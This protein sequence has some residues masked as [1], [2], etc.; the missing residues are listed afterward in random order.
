[1]SFIAGAVGSKA[2]FPDGAQIDHLSENTVGHGVRVRGISDL[3]TYPVIAGDVGE[4]FEAA[5][6]PGYTGTANTWS[7]AS[8]TLS[9]KKGRWDVRYYG[10]LQCDWVTQNGSASVR[11]YNSTAASEITGARS[12]AISSLASSSMSHFA[13]V[14]N[15]KVVDLAVDS[16]LILQIASSTNATAFKAQFVLDVTGGIT[17]NESDGKIVAVRIA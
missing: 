14:S 9:L 6:L 11:L 5:V 10:L 3:T 1:M 16:D 2:V 13:H 12:V 7:T 15:S 8:A 17:G 4:S